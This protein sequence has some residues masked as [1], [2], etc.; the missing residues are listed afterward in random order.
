MIELSIAEIFDKWAEYADYDPEQTSF[1][2]FSVNY[3]L[4]RIAKNVEKLLEWDATS[5]IPLLYLRQAM[6][7]FYEHAQMKVFDIIQEPTA[8]QKH[9]DMWN[10]LNSEEALAVE[11]QFKRTLDS[12]E[13]A[14]NPQMRLTGDVEEGASDPYD[15]TAIVDRL[16]E[17]LPKLHESVWIRSDEPIAAQTKVTNTIHIFDSLREAIAALTDVEDCCALCYIRQPLSADGWFAVFIKS[18]GNLVSIDE[19]L[20]EV[21]PGQH[22]NRRNGRYLEDHAFDIFPYDEIFEYGEF[23]Y[24]GYAQSYRIDETKLSLASLSPTMRLTTSVLLMLAQKRFEGRVLEEEPLLVDSLMR[25]NR[26]PDAGLC[27]ALATTA[28]RALAHHDEAQSRIV[29]ELSTDVIKHATCVKDL[30]ELSHTHFRSDPSG[31]FGDFDVDE[32]DRVNFVALYGDGFVCDYSHLFE[33]NSH[34]LPDPN[35]KHALRNSEFVATYPHMKAIAYKELRKQLADHIRNR[36][37]DEFEEMGGKRAIVDLFERAIAD[38]AQKFFEMAARV[39]STNRIVDYNGKGDMRNDISSSVEGIPGRWYM[40]N[41]TGH[42][43]LSNAS[44]PNGVIVDDNGWHRSTYLEDPYYENKAT[45]LF[46]M[47]FLNAKEIEETLGIELPRPI[48]LWRNP[49]FKRRYNGNHILD[50]TDPVGDLYTPLERYD[51][52]GERRFELDGDHDDPFTVKIG[53]SKRSLKKL[54]K[55]LGLPI[56]EMTKKCCDDLRI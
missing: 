14:M 12:L 34:A 13:S 20:N 56:P 42:V 33:S 35:D 15:I 54:A 6:R 52:N 9:I 17:G 28:P 24:K 21:Y 39:W 32:S 25:V 45:L 50:I 22:H 46:T 53:M 10:L 2:L 38:N 48:K 16:M 31:T 40:K 37:F 4:N 23:D 44:T 41:A 7:D 3:M 18:N 51:R 19:R 27:T 30:D 26:L 43:S 5:T 49:S 47:E 11:E 36:M 8:P 1:K 29:S 55:E